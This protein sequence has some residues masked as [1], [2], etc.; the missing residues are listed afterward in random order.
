MIQKLRM[1]VGLDIVLFGDCY[2]DLISIR[3]FYFSQLFFYFIGN[4]LA[5]FTY[6][7][8]LSWFCY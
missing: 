8:V 6:E 4:I 7:C 1:E 3:F 2:G 5:E